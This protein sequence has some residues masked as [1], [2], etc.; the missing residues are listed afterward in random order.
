MLLLA[1][2]AK[3]QGHPSIAYLAYLAGTVAACC[4]AFYMFRLYFLV[5]TGRRR[6]GMTVRQISHSVPSQPR[7][8]Q[9]SRP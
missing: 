7:A 9:C 5:F 4:T 1:H 8:V 2:L 6:P 3:I